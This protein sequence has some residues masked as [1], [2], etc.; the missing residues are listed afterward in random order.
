MPGTRYSVFNPDGESFVPDQDKFNAQLQQM[1]MQNM[2]NL[3]GIN[4]QAREFNIGDS[5]NRWNAQAQYGLGTQKLAQSGHQFDVSTDLAKQQLAALL[6]YQNK[7]L[8]AQYEAPRA[9][10]AMEQQQW[11]EGS[12]S[13][14]LAQQL[15][16]AQLLK[17]QNA[18]K[19]MAGLV[20]QTGPIDPT[21]AALAGGGNIGDVLR[22][23][24]DQINQQAQPFLRQADADIA[25]NTP[26][27]R[28][29]LATVQGS[30]QGLGYK[31]APQATEL[32]ATPFADWSQNKEFQAPLTDLSSRFGTYTKNADT[33]FGDP[34][35]TGDKEAILQ[36]ATRI[37]A[38]ANKAGYEK[39]DVDALLKQ[40]ALDQLAKSK[41]S[42][43]GGRR[44][45]Y[46]ASNIDSLTAALGLGNLSGSDTPN[47]A[48]TAGHALGGLT[49][50]LSDT[51]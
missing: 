15:T 16:Q 20:N 24:N 3:A 42:W 36:D 45:P 21:K 27:S 32:N 51:L 40:A 1:A 34:D 48:A 6:N 14:A 47:A 41:K 17:E 11:N 38:A 37:R 7:S 13:R 2:G 19:Y 28:K 4:E 33:W 23:Q 12:Q 50:G 31:G 5:T 49:Y 35:T 18:Q 39:T 44:T 29:H 30:L 9:H 26:N 10:L 25:A 43:Y 22:V 8:D 46:G